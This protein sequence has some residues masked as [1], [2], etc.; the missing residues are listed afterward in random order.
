VMP[1]WWPCRLKTEDREFRQM[2]LP[3]AVSFKQ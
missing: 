2:P 3:P 1:G